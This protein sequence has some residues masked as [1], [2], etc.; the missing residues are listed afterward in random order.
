MNP[1]HA[2]DLLGQWR[3]AV[4]RSLRWAELG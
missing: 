2:A 4:K 3:E 1:A